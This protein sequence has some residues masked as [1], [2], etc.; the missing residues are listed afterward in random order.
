MIPLLVLVLSFLMTYIRIFGLMRCADGTAWGTRVLSAEAPRQK[1]FRRKAMPAFAFILLCSCVI[2]GFWLLDHAPRLFQPVTVFDDTGKNVGIYQTE[3]ADIELMREKPD[4]LGW[5]EAWG[6]SPAKEKA[7]ICIR[8]HMTP[9]IN[10]SPY[11]YTLTDIGN[12][13]HDELIRN[14]LTEINQTYGDS[15]VLIRLA[16]EMENNDT[17]NWYPWQYKGGEKDYIH[18]WRHVVSIGREVAPHV[19]WIWSPNRM[20]PQSIRWY[21][22]DEY[23]DYI[24]ITLNHKANRVPSYPTFEDYFRQ[25]GVEKRFN[26]INKKIILS[27]VGYANQDETRRGEYL[28]SIFDWVEQDDRICGVVFFNHN[29]MEESQYRFSDSRYLMDIWYNGLQHMHQYSKNSAVT[30]L[31]EAKKGE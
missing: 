17:G 25:E 9:L 3:P 28:Q 11:D 20:T 7:Q 12:G 4:I 27:E 1:S 14:Y 23:V 21:P 5:F 24:S 29:K 31:Q 10:W 15:T 26:R 13:K 8:E 6:T 2:G 30:A 18:M 22:G 16:H 19:R